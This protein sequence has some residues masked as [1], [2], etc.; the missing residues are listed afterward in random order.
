MWLFLK[1]F[2]THSLIHCVAELSHSLPKPSH[3]GT[4]FNAF[5]LSLH[6]Y[7]LNFSFFIVELF[8]F[9]ISSPFI[10][11]CWEEEINAQW[12]F[13]SFCHSNNKNT[14]HFFLIF[15]YATLCVTHCFAVW[16]KWKG[17]VESRQYIYIYLSIYNL[18]ILSSIFTW[19]RDEELTFQ[20]Y[21]NKWT[22]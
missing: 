20:L 14:L 2:F 16:G 22:A 1:N 21:R 17:K 8:F 19:V 12:K 7:A 9:I 11:N 3:I 13:L 6:Y 5:F 4:L 10:S 15:P 18:S